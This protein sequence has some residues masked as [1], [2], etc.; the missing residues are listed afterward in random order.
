MLGLAL[1]S[2]NSPSIIALT[3]Q[4]LNP[5]RK[6]FVKENK[7]SKGAYEIF[8]NNKTIKLTIFATGSE[9][10]LAIDVS[11]KL[12]TQNIYSKVV[13]VPCQ[14]LFE[15]QSNEYKRKILDE[16]Q[17]KISIEAATTN[18]WKKFVGEKGLSFGIDNFGK[19]APYKDIYNFFGL[20]VDNIFKK[21]KRLVNI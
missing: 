18:N 16:S 9:V 4:K 2:Y 12:A 10:N 20:T 1:E 6:E 11:H 14:E 5:V 21:V 17:Y 15:K 13:S 8:R 7:C 19:S 3:R